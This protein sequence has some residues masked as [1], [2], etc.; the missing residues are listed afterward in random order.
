MAKAIAGKSRFILDC[1]IYIY[2]FHSIYKKQLARCYM[3][4]FDYDGEEFEK[5]LDDIFENISTEELIK[6]LIECGLEI[7]QQKEKVSK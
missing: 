5:K 3:D 4:I 2:I 6:E 7:K 1:I